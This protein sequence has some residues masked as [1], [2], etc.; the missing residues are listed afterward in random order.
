[1]AAQAGGRECCAHIGRG[2]A[3]HYVKMVHNGIKYADMQ[4]IA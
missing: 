4:L 2:G 1:M 3:A